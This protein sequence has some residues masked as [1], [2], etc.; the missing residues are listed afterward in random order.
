MYNRCIVYYVKYRIFGSSF[1]FE[2]HLMFS[3]FTPSHFNGFG[4]H[5]CTE[6]YMMALLGAI[7]YGYFAS[8]NL[9]SLNSKKLCDLF[10]GT[11]KQKIES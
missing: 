5:I 11:R 6:F 1:L 9:L 10:P 3:A 8:M 2:P 4:W 7:L